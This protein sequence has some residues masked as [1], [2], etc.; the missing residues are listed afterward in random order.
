VGLVLNT[1]VAI[2]GTTFIASVLPYKHTTL[3]GPE[4]PFSIAIAGALG[5]AMQYARRKDSSSRWVWICPAVWFIVGVGW[6]NGF[7]SQ[8]SHTH[9]VAAWQ[10]AFA[11]PLV[12]SVSF[13]LAAF[14]ASVARS[15]HEL[16]VD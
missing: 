10:Y 13:S 15:K 4:L 11:V 2:L 16:H 3:L 7:A 5:F 8:L 14:A 1:V 9:Q 12:R 6:R